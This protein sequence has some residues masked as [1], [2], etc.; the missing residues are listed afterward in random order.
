M[1]PMVNTGVIL[2]KKDNAFLGSC[3]IFRYP[4]TVVTATHC[5][6]DYSDKEILLVFPGNSVKKV[7]NVKEI[8]QHNN[9]DIS[10]MI[11]PDI[12]E[13]DITWPH[14]TLFDDHS[15]GEDFTT[16]GYPQEYVQSIPQPTPRL[17]KGH[18]QRFFNHNSH[19]GY[20]YHAAEL[21][22]GCPGGLSGAPVF[23]SQFQ[24]RLYGL[25]TEN[26]K[27][28]TELETVLEVEENGNTFKELYHNVINYGI[29]LW[30]PS[31]SDW[32]DLHI[33]PVSS[34]E[35]NR[36]A[37]NQQKWREAQASQITPL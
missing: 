24:G 13:D 16:F 12:H 10:I 33:P 8:I 5:V 7:F 23:N 18:I 30:L 29:A 36:R 37:I 1:N 19:L 14:Y 6:K 28:T 27:T 3:F 26:I 4:S 17:F 22:I 20:N 35:I 2:R 34:E 11:A 21:S 9:A 32:I 15:W 25:I 31:V